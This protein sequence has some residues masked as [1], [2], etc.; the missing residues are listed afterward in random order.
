MHLKQVTQHHQSF[1]AFF[2]QHYDHSY[3][4]STFWK[5]IFAS[6]E[7]FPN[8]NH[9]INF[10]RGTFLVGMGHETGYSESE[11]KKV[12]EHIFNLVAKSIPTSY[13]ETLKEP[14]IGSPVFF[15]NDV[16]TMSTCYLLNTITSYVIKMLSANFKNPNI[17]EIGPGWGAVA[18]QIIQAIQPNL[19]YIID[20]PE[21]L[22]LSSYFLTYSHLEYNSSFSF[23][24]N[25]I[26]NKSIVYSFPNMHK[27]LPVKFDIIFNTFS[28]QEMEK[29]IV[30]DYMAWIHENLNENGL[31]IS[32]NSHGKTSVAQPSDYTYPGLNLIKLDNFRKSPENLLNTIPYLSVFKKETMTY[33]IATYNKIGHLAQ[34]GI[35]ITGLDNNLSESADINLNDDIKHIIK[36][37]NSLND[38]SDFLKLWNK[39]NYSQHR[40]AYLKINTF[41][42]INKCL[43]ALNESLVNDFSWLKEECE[44]LISKKPRKAIGMYIKKIMRP[45]LEY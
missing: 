45:I 15:N 20:L 35:D 5:D 19:Y 2:N 10:Q 21:N 41:A 1:N 18:E 44:Q 22:I 7:N 17:A 9:L 8:P 30:H 32:I 28:F 6:R 23:L 40:F 12:W 26:P 33:S 39:S 43:P 38:K 31:L 29:E 3:P 36:L 11:E 37:Y 16:C 4:V 25:S 14:T 13:L 27:K 34:L 42:C 24:Q